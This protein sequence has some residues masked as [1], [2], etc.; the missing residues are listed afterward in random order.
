MVVRSFDKN[1][2]CY[3]FLTFKSD[4]TKGSSYFSHKIWIKTS[5]HKKIQSKITTLT[6]KTKNP[7]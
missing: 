6:T 4:Q 3:F 1:Q 2:I 7:N 5:D